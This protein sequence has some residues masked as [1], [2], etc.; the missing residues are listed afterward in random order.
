M[1]QEY[2]KLDSILAAV[3]YDVPMDDLK[4]QLKVLGFKLTGVDGTLIKASDF[5]KLCD[6]VFDDADEKDSYMRRVH[7]HN[8]EKQKGG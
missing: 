3:D 8:K 6:E 1:A 4:H 7:E 5:A 2:V